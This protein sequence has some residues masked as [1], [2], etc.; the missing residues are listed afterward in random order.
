MKRVRLIAL[1]MDGTLLDN[2]HATVPPR[3]ALA[4]ERAIQAGIHICISTGRMLEDASDFAHRL[5][6]PCMLIACNG[7]RA[8]DAPLPE[9]NVF[10]RR[11]LEPRDALAVLDYIRDEGLMINALEDGRV[12]T[13]PTAEYPEYHL[14]RRKLVE[15]D[16]GEAA[17][18]AALERGTMKLF[19]R[20][21]FSETDRIAKIEKELRSAFPELA[22]TSSSPDNIEIMPPHAGKGEAL[23]RMALYLGLTREEVMAVGDAQ[24]D[25]SM[26]RYAYHSV[27]MGNAV[28]EVRKVCRYQTGRNDECGVAQIIERVLQSKEV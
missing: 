13:I 9:G 27:S 1:D 12:S 14:A 5:G 19:I 20:G 17:V 4:M 8:A 18:R 3:N 11:T 10:W 24:N 22:I 7:T 16:Y 6:L 2:D 23:E 26:L 21:R 25:L 15:V 28:E